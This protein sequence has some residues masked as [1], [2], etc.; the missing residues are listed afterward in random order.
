M[1]GYGANLRIEVLSMG[2]DI[3][4]RILTSF[5]DPRRCSLPYSVQPMTIDD[6]KSLSYR[7]RRDVTKSVAHSRHFFVGYEITTV[8]A[9]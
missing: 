1:T 9:N 5:C 6:V 8:H 4:T 3:N 2:Q 7:Y